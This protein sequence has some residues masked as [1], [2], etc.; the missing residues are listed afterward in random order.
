MN[1]YNQLT[2]DTIKE[3]YKNT[4]KQHKQENQEVSP[5]PADDHKEQTIQHSKDKQETKRN[6]K[7]PQ[8]APPW[9]GQ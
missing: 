1:R 6:H 2:R 3:S 5:F 9:N 4:R 8:E 7:K